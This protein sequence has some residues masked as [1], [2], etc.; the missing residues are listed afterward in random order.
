MVTDTPG[1]DTD[2]PGW[3]T[4]TH[5]LG[6]AVPHRTRQGTYKK[7]CVQNMAVVTHRG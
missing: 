1:W 7:I 3:D 2:T 4:D 5:G 6:T